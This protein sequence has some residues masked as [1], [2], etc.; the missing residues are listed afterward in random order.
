MRILYVV[1]DFPGS[2]RKGYQVRAAAFANYLGQAHEVKVAASFPGGTADATLGPR[3]RLSQAEAVIRLLARGWPLQAS[4]FD[5][6][7]VALKALEF[8]QKMSADI[9][10]I[11]T[12]RMPFTT[13]A[14]A[15]VYPTVADIVDSQARHM[16]M[17]ASR[18]RFP[19]AALFRHEAVAF[20]RLSGTLRRVVR[21]VVV[22]AARETRD[23]PD[24]EVIPNGA[25]ATARSGKPTIDVVFSGNLDY[26]P[27]VDA[28]AE[29]CGAIVPKL[30][31]LGLAPRVTVAGRSP[32]ASV[33]AACASSGV[34]VLS[35]VEDMSAVLRRAR[36]AVAPIRSATGS[37]LKVLEALS[38]GTPVLVYPEAAAG[39]QPGLTGVVICRDA[40][41]M[42][43]VAVEILTGT[44]TVSV[45]GEQFRWEL[46]AARFQRL[47]ES[48][49]A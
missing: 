11:T 8:G 34:D 20:V 31:A 36:L 39:L 25:F 24:A 48:V 40:D 30:R 38:A 9:A 32:T 22:C 43:R 41:A 33:L 5:G 47:L 15:Q 23:Y 18:S 37:Q 45:E 46:Q 12:E 26:W 14:L 28:V 27:N 29:L 44:R 21:R 42:A 35:N 1:P 4:L 49:V 3:G 6:P 17:R 13:T 10:V 19:V 7:D 16:A 2:P